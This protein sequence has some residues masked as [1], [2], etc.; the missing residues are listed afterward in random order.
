[1]TNII[2]LC[3]DYCDLSIPFFIKL[4]SS[5][6]EARLIVTQ[7]D[8][9]IYSMPYNVSKTLTNYETFKKV[10]KPQ[11]LTKVNLEKNTV[12]YILTSKFSSITD[13]NQRNVQ[14]VTSSDIRK[15]RTYLYNTPSHDITLG[16]INNIETTSYE[17]TVKIPKVYDEEDV[18]I[19]VTDITGMSI[20]LTFNKDEYVINFK[21]KLLGNNVYNINLTYLIKNSS[22]VETSNKNYTLKVIK[23]K[24]EHY[25]HIPVY[26]NFNTYIDVDN[27]LNIILKNVPKNI[28]LDNLNI[29][30]PNVYHFN[31]KEQTLIQEKNN[32]FTLNIKIDFVGL[33]NMPNQYVIN[34]DNIYDVITNDIYPSRK[35][36]FRTNNFH[37]C[38]HKTNFSEIYLRSSNISEL[39]DYIFLVNETKENISVYGLVGYSDKEIKVIYDRC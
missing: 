1:M 38:V 15:V 36:L 9:E 10:L 2:N 5:G 14:I 17:P 37:T 23:K 12:F 6:G 20:P 11:S 35:V 3:K 34:I 33:L 8:I 24:L 29:S 21:D 31:I 26:E 25:H 39:E 22:V 13:W 18:L 28:S 16:L 19:Q 27:D 4:D 7:N 30:I 32:T